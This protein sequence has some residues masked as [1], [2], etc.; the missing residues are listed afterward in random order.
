MFL[1]GIEFVFISFIFILPFL[2]IAIV[3]LSNFSV[4]FVMCSLFPES[5]FLLIF[6]VNC[7]T[8]YKISFKCVMEYDEHCANTL[9]TYTRDSNTQ[10]VLK[11]IHMA[12]CGKCSQMLCE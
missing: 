4:A 5:Y 8:C 6:S 9:Y 11:Y 10:F 2:R 3:N 7:K 1:L 12:T